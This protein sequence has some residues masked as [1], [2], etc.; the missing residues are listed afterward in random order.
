[1]LKKRYS[2]YGHYP[3]TREIL[4]VQGLFICSL[5]NRRLN[6]MTLDYHQSVNQFVIKKQIIYDLIAASK[7]SLPIGSFYCSSTYRGLDCS[8]QQSKV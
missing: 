7:Y 6:I 3:V 1:M 4:V 8:H 5:Y 2:H